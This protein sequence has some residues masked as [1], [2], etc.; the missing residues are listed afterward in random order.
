MSRGNNKKTPWNARIGNGTGGYEWL[1]SFQTEEEAALAY[2][3][4]AVEIYGDDAILNDVECA[5][6]LFQAGVTR[7]VYE[8]EYRDTAGIEYLST[9]GVAIEKFNAEND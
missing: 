2:N 6:Q 1:G 4:L 9:H 8:Q 3:R 5:I 7:V